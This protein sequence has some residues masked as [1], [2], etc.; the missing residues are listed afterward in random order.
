MKT[1]ICRLL[2]VITAILVMMLG[3]PRDGSGQHMHGGEPH[4]RG[5]MVHTMGM[6]SDIMKDINQ[7]KSEG[8]MTPEQQR[9]VSDMVSQM[10]HMMRQMSTAQPRQVEE[11][12]HRQ[13]KQMQERLK[14]LKRQVQKQKK[15]AGLTGTEAAIR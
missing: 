12:Q 10:G 13:L 2:P 6:M 5:Q 11:E 8:W 9:E 3:M 4:V 1:K 7:L 15:R 14:A